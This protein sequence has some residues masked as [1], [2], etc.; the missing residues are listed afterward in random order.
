MLA[1]VDEVNFAVR[2]VGRGGISLNIWNAFVSSSQ[3]TPS[4][5]SSQSNILSLQYKPFLTDRKGRQRFV[6]SHVLQIYPS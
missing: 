1:E 2:A 4:V 5:E 3:A 6:E